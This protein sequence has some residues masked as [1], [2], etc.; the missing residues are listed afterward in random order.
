MDRTTDSGVNLGRWVAPHG[1]N[2]FH[3]QQF[4]ELD[5]DSAMDNPFWM[6]RKSF[7]TADEAVRA[8][9]RGQSDPTCKVTG[10]VSSD[11]YY[12]VE[13]SRLID[14]R[15]GDVLATFTKGT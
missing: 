15:A 7:S 2:Q 4:V 14:V 9:E 12:H 5:G 8:F 6:T 1:A 13:S 3:I 11:L 10:F